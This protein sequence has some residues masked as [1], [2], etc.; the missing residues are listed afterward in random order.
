MAEEGPQSFV[1]LHM[2]LI[3]SHSIANIWS[4]NCLGLRCRV[5]SCVR[6]ASVCVCV[7]VMN[8]NLIRA[9]AW[10][11]LKWLGCS[12]RVWKNQRRL[13]SPTQ[14]S[15]VHVFS[16]APLR[17][18]S[19]WEVPEFMFNLLVLKR[20]RRFHN[21]LEPWKA[22]EGR[23]ESYWNPHFLRRQ[24]RVA[25]SMQQHTIFNLNAGGNA[26]EFFFFWFFQNR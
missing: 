5:I 26:V 4:L 21:M 10:R 2:I 22:V 13:R 1:S 12:S 18:T 3:A 19:M 25:L 23:G 11:A 15:N 17:L 8:V 16:F 7:C 14:C 20:L 9:W 6:R 24:K